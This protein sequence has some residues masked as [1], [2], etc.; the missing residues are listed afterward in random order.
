MVA[1]TVRASE[2][3]VDPLGEI[4]ACVFSLGAGCEGDVAPFGCSGVICCGGIV[5]AAGDGAVRCAGADGTME[6]RSM[7]IFVPGLRVPFSRAVS[8]SWASAAVK[9]STVPLSVASKRRTSV[10]LASCIELIANDG[11]K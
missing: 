10:F 5:A 6:P 3:G 1:G 11:F 2:G 4:G 9:R 7:G 8:I